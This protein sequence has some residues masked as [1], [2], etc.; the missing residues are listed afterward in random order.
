M[1]M[2]RI[3]QY[4]YN[5]YK[6]TVGLFTNKRAASMNKAPKTVQ[7][8]SS[9]RIADGK[10]K[11]SVLTNFPNRKIL[12]ADHRKFLVI[13]KNLRVRSSCKNILQIIY[14]SQRR[15]LRVSD[16]EFCVEWFKYVWIVFRKF[17]L[18]GTI[19]TDLKAGK[20]WVKS[21][22]SGLPKPLIHVVKVW[23]NLSTWEK[24][25]IIT[26]I[27]IHKSL[28]FPV[29]T[30]LSTIVDPLTEDQQSFIDGF[31]REIPVFM[32]STGLRRFKNIKLPPISGRSFYLNPQH[33]GRQW[34]VSG[35]NG[36]GL[37]AILIDITSLSQNPIIIEKLDKI[38]AW[39]GSQK[40]VSDQGSTS[41]KYYI[42]LLG[43]NILGILHNI[44]I[45]NATYQHKSYP[46][47]GRITHFD[48]VGGKKR[49]IALGNWMVQGALKPLHSI[50]IAY[51]RNLRDNDCTYNQ[52]IVFSW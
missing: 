42:D 13:I 40:S 24:I 32:N 47:L 5:W 46:A 12:L 8:Y 6:R 20:I 16:P 19:P 44:F 35:P 23:N 3:L 31:C 25:L 34:V 48:D 30:D 36:K 4:I 45:T 37:L 33:M 50:I 14:L 52:D 39:C 17:I 38:A 10:A 22:S 26:A 18:E 2:F 1:G 43:W 49:Y 7:Q 27:R 11:K 21:C 28:E 15:V 51:L 9:T 29:K 41:I